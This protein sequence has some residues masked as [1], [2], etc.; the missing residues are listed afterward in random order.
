MNNVLVG[1]LK[2]DLTKHI[3]EDN[4]KTILKFQDGSG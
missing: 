3:Q 2:E 4:I 1:K